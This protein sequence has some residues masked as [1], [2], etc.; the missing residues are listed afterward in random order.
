MKEKLYVST[1]NYYPGRIAL[2]AGTVFSEAQWIEAG[3]KATGLAEHIARKYI[4]EAVQVKPE[5]PNVEA[6][7]VDALKV[8]T[9]QEE[10]SPVVDALKVDAPQEEASPVVEKEAPTG[11]W[12][13][14]VEELDP[15]PLGALNTM[16]KDTAKKAGLPT[17][18][19][20]KD[21]DALIAKMTSEGIPQ[22]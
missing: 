19:A 1:A 8:D 6:P 22:D 13:F 17:V 3:G 18:R 12:N 4:T 15:L 20:F 9:P 11:L 2:P 7:V 14:T 16:Y 5:A 10:A 21:K